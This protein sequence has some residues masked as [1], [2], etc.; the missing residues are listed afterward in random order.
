MAEERSE[1]RE[2]L[3]SLELEETASK[4]ER[5]L[6]SEPDNVR[7]LAELSVCYGRMHR[8]D[9]ALDLARRAVESGP[10][11]APAHYALGTELFLRD[12]NDEAEREL[13][14]A[15]ELDPALPRAYFPLAQVLADQGEFDQA[16]EELATARELADGDQAELAHGWY[17][18]AYINL[19]RGDIEEAERCIHEALELEDANPRIAALAYANL[20]TIQVRR[21]QYLPAIENLEKAVQ[22]NPYLCGAYWRLGQL[23]LFRRRYSDA[24]RALDAA[25]RDPRVAGPRLHYALGMA[26]SKTGD[27]ERAREH[28]LEALNSGLMGRSALAAR[29]ALILSGAGARW[30]LYI[31]GGGL[32]AWF[33][34]TRLPTPTLVFLA[35]LIGLYIAYR[36]FPRRR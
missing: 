17:V 14:Q 28:Y 23:Y 24:V 7:A 20:G 4:W 36:L 27:Q 8:S 16:E 21:R 29:S 15:I 33:A 11:H 31:L 18:E 13:R 12:E 1:T 6:A 22:L 30:T 5:I 10:D 34:V 35:A 25:T 2:D 26:Y 32:A 9:E 19:A 3:C